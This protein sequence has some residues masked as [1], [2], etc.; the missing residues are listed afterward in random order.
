MIEKGCWIPQSLEW[1]R[2]NGIE[3]ALDKR[4]L[5]TGGN[6][7][8]SNLKMFYFGLMRRLPWHWRVS[9]MNKLRR[10]LISY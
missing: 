5:L 9:L 8:I 6:K 2:E 4:P 7:L 1:A 10:I 3:L